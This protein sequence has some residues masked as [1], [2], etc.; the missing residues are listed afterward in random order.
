MLKICYTDNFL[1]A[2]Y[3]DIANRRFKD[4]DNKTLEKI[5]GKK[6]KSLIGIE[7]KTLLIGEYDK[8]PK[9]DLDDAKKDELKKVFKYQDKFQQ[10]ISDLFKKHLDI[11]T[12]YYCNID[13]INIFKTTNKNIL[14][15]YTLDH[16]VNKATYPYLALS[17]YNLI[18]VCYIC[19]SKLKKDKDIGDM[20][21]THSKFDFDTRVKF[22]TFITNPN[23]QIENES[24]FKLLLKEDFSNLYDKYI[25]VLQLDGRYEYHKY[26]VI[27]LINRRKEYPD[28]RIK[29]LS[30]LTQKPVEEIKQDLF[31][32]YLD[33][34]LHKRP[35]SKLIKD[36]T[37]ELGLT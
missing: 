31:G 12:C 11:H 4:F 37:T 16:I 26:K 8:L 20:V 5:Y 29:E 18:P 6:F 7:L 27:E 19:N 2:Y 9:I 10:H 13:F 30:D 32:E 23:L 33:F 1:E 35:L 28:S 24:D 36:I 15:G 3:D 22:K 14:T 25:E 17:L 34:D 21:P